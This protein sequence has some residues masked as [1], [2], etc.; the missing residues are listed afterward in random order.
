MTTTTKLENDFEE[1]SDASSECDLLDYPYCAKEESL[2][3]IQ[4]EFKQNLN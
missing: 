4:C 1:E 3:G 2:I